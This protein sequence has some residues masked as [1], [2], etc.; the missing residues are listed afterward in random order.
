MKSLISCWNHCYRRWDWVLVKNKCIEFNTF[1]QNEKECC[2]FYWNG[3]RRVVYRHLL[4]NV[5]NTITRQRHLILFYIVILSKYPF[6]EEISRFRLFVSS[7][8][9]IWLIFEI[10]FRTLVRNECVLF[11]GHWLKFITTN[12]L[13]YPVNFQSRYYF[14]TKV[15]F[16]CD[17]EIRI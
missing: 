12:G 15:S 16:L 14:W 17:N 7:Y 2:D 9:I 4:S 6:T 3:G 5:V 13:F 10:P 1:F 8:L 11:F